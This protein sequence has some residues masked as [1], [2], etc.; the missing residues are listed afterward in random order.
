LLQETL[1]DY[2]DYTVG[3]DFCTVSTKNAQNWGENGGDVWNKAHCAQFCISLFYLL[4][5]KSFFN[6]KKIK[7][8]KCALCSLLH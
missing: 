6:H 4:L 8:Q 5:M 1:S 7:S 3:L 2:G